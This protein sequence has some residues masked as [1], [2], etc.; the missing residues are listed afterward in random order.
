M[1]DNSY[2]T[3]LD[4]SIQDNSG[5]D[6][7]NLGD[8]I[9]Y[10]SIKQILEDLF[11]GKEIKRISTHQYIQ[12]KE[13][14]IINDSLFAF[15]GGTNILTSDIRNFPRLSPVKRKGF[16]LFPGFRNLVLL[17][18]GWSAYQPPVDLPTR[19]YYKQILKKK[20]CIP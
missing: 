8:L 17:G 16:Y 14:G 4:P 11:P 5:I 3:L 20:S 2:I 7:D 15:V 19:I 6:S 10:Q 9:I 13:T 18:T 1:N 12:K